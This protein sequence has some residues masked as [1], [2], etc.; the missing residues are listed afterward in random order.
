MP[1]ETSRTFPGMY[2]TQYQEAFESREK[3]KSDF[4]TLDPRTHRKGFVPSTS[5]PNGLD[6]HISG[7]PA[8]EALVHNLAKERRKLSAKGNPPQTLMPVWDRER[9]EWRLGQSPKQEFTLGTFGSQFVLSHPDSPENRFF[10]ASE[11]IG[12]AARHVFLRCEGPNEKHV[13]LNSLGDWKATVHERPSTSAAGCMKKHRPRQFSKDHRP[14]SAAAAS[15]D[16]FP[17][18]M[19][20]LQQTK[21]RTFLTKSLKES[22]RVTE[23]PTWSGVERSRLIMPYTT[24]NNRNRFYRGA[25]HVGSEV[26]KHPG[27]FHRYRTA[28]WSQNQPVEKAL[29]KHGPRRPGDPFH[30][31]RVHGEFTMV[32]GDSPAWFNVPEVSIGPKAKASEI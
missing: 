18:Y 14:T 12:E 17:Q 27:R 10:R 2:T 26:M 15:S 32:S 7:L 20:K 24:A 31:I 9:S 1:E 4:A 29:A 11:K 19:S 5:H 16:L 8:E 30:P 13:T 6:I 25:D 21:Q 22:E 28:A 3:E 23:P